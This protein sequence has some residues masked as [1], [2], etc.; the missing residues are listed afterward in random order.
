MGMAASMGSLLVAAGAKGHRSALPNARLMVHQPHGGATVHS[1]NNTSELI[2]FYI[3]TSKRYCYHG[4]G[5]FKD[6]EAS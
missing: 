2:G 4:G 5:D 6:E 1:T 3:G